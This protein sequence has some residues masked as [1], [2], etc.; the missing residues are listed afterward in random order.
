MILV[1][2]VHIIASR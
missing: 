2:C 1:I